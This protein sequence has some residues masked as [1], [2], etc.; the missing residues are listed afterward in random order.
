[1][2]GMEPARAAGA[3]PRGPYECPVCEY[4][5]LSVKP[6]AVWPP[7][8]GAHIE[9]PYEHAL[10]RPSYEVC[11]RCGF[12]FGNDD[13]PGTAAPSSFEQYREEWLDDGAPWFMA[14]PDSADGNPGN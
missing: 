3:L 11:M 6:Y 9:P 10:G 8:L 4:A 14:P 5:G 12:E 2:T 1:M 13:N 7:P